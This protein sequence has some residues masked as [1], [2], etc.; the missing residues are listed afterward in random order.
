MT[1]RIPLPARLVLLA[2]PLLALTGCPRAVRETQP[3]NGPDP[4]ASI[5][6]VTTERPKAKDIKR[7][8]EQPAFVEAYEETP[9]IAGIP[10]FVG[11]VYADIGQVFDT[12][13]KLAELSVP[14]L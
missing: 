1:H 8:I 3:G 6:T 14:E 11:K 12:G 13:G 2:L 5:P 4:G 7:V 9:L 10:G